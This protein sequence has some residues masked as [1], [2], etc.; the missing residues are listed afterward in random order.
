M[1]IM[2]SLK[3]TPLYTEMTRPLLMVSIFA[4]VSYRHAVYNS[5]IADLTIIKAWRN[6]FWC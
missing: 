1:G 4:G 6:V 2:D 5:L 3:S